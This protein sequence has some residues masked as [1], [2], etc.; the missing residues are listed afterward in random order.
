MA[1]SEKTFDLGNG[2]VLKD[3]TRGIPI[4]T[5]Q[6][7]EET[8]IE[9]D[10]GAAHEMLVRWNNWPGQRKM[11][12]KKVEE[13]RRKMANK[14]WFRSVISIARQIDEKHKP[15]CDQEGVQN[16]FILNGQHT[17]KAIATMEEAIRTRITVQFFDLTWNQ[18]EILFSQFDDHKARRPSD[19]LGPVSK[20]FGMST[21]TKRGLVTETPLV[22]TKM[23]ETIAKAIYWVENDG[24]SPQPKSP[25]KDVLVNTVV[26]RQEFVRWCIKAGSDD[27]G[28]PFGKIGD[29]SPSRIWK[30]GLIAVMY[31]IYKD[32]DR[33]LGREFL[34]NLTSGNR[35]SE[36]LN[37][38]DE[39]RSA[40]CTRR[41]AK[42]WNKRE[43]ARTA[44]MVIDAF[45]AYVKSSDLPAGYRLP[46][47]KIA[48]M[49]DVELSAPIVSTI[50]TGGHDAA[51]TDLA[52]TGN[53]E[54][55]TGTIDRRRT[56][57]DAYTEP[58]A[59]LGEA[60]KAVASEAIRFDAPAVA[61]E[62]PPKRG[63]KAK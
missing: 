22:K 28:K 39:L 17:L 7:N 49:T 26:Q 62:D 14:L 12:I 33:A 47:A 57:D 23:L 24:F 13:Y 60:G 30:I 20:L 42:E 8:Q 45:N 46:W 63:R 3:S 5:F 51:G 34:R 27:P 59:P 19:V 37:P 2:K 38:I 50:E 18:I 29:I 52:V 35:K 6:P 11:D 32:G 54:V 36:D 15:I 25:S 10:S 40:L 48:N 58:A 9:L 31:M 53:T 61:T 44:W 56:V 41:D 4:S 21:Q 16:C 1:S 55:K 43:H